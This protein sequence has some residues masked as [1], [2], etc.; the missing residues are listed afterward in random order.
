[1]ESWLYSELVPFYHLLDPLEEHEDEASEFGDVLHGAVDSAATLLELGSGA[2]HG[3][4]FIKE[5]FERVVLSDLSSPMLERSQVLNPDCEHLTGDM[6]SLRLNR[7]FDCVLIHDAIS[8]LRSPDELKAAMLTSFEHL[9]EGGAALLIPDCLK[10]SF[11]DWHEDHEGD[12]ETRSL[13]CM[14]WS[15]DPDPLDDTHVTDFAFLLREN[16][17]V[18]AVHDRHVFGLFSAKLWCEMATQVGFLVT[19]IQRPLPEEYLQ[20]AYTDQMFLLRRPK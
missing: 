2:G 7:R 12:D 17:E 11:K 5:R 8:Y 1:M 19:V 13:R 9:R 20:S 3:A 6:R 15:H 14:A 18:R 10:E 4:H 16:G